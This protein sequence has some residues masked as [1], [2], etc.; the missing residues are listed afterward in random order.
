M[1]PQDFIGLCRRLPSPR[2]LGILTEGPVLENDKP[3]EK[4]KSLMNHPGGKD[5]EAWDK[6]PY[7]HPELT[8]S[9]RLRKAKVA[10]N[11]GGRSGT[12]GSLL[13]DD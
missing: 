9:L 5:L 4:E 7:P 6:P 12:S 1:G 3:T 11:I 10:Q 8:R 13:S 2:V